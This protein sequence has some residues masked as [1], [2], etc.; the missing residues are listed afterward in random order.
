MPPHPPTS[1]RPKSPATMNLAELEVYIEDL[2]RE[3]R[4]PA[5]CPACRRDRLQVRISR[6]QDRIIR[7]RRENKLRRAAEAAAN[8]TPG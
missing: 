2:E 8:G 4:D 7:L 3:M 6:A 1:P 5:G